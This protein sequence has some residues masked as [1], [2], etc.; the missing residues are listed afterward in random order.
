[1]DRYYG[2]LDIAEKYGIIKKVSTRYELSNG[3]KVFGKNINEEP[4][5]FFT[6]DVMKRLEEAVAKEF[7]YGQ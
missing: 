5:K 1:L 2:L 3:V 7:K 4:E 6:E